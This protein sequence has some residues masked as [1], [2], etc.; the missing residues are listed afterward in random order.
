MLT[1]M[2]VVKDVCGMRQ[3]IIRSL[4]HKHQLSVLLS[5][6]NNSDILLSREY[7]FLFNTT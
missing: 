5:L 3:T 4:E 6:N 7:N 1:H 2:G